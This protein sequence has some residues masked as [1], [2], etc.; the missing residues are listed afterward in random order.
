MPLIYL[1]RHGESESNIGLPTYN[2]AEVRLTVK[3]IFEAE[4]IAKFFRRCPNLIVTSPYLR[5]RET[6]TPTLR[7]F[8][9]TKC[10]VW[11]VQEFT[12]LSYLKMSRT[13]IMQRRPRVDKYWDICDPSY[14]DGEGCESFIDLINRTKSI[15]TK[16]KDSS[17]ASLAI[18][19]HGQ[20]IKAFIWLLLSRS[21]NIQS[22]HMKQFLAFLNSFSI[23]NG[24]IIKIRF[25][26]SDRFWI[27][28]VITN[29]ISG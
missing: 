2:P 5:A 27:S 7:R 29:H 25:H 21:Q 9:N 14:T 10:E 15:I 8:P 13:T 16:I 11:S 4:C 19:T 1:I 23:I 24:S 28:N 6:A 17:D 12:Y 22:Q 18:F 3:G 20:F 26:K